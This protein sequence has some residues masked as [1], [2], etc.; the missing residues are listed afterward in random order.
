MV[1]QR[2]D[3]DRSSPQDLGYLRLADDLTVA[4]VRL[5]HLVNRQGFSDTFDLSSESC[6]RPNLQAYT[7]SAS[8]PLKPERPFHFR[9]PTAHSKCPTPRCLT[10]IRY[11]IKA[12]VPSR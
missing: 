12:G 3:L 9:K 6:V 5:E 2:Q 10:R 11:E 8:L 4:F 7:K 1:E